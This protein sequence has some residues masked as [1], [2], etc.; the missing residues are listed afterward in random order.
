MHWV[1]LV[2]VKIDRLFLVELRDSTPTEPKLYQCYLLRSVVFRRAYLLALD[3]GETNSFRLAAQP[4]QEGV[5]LLV[6]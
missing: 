4:L 5:G 2:R 3:N 6:R 1:G